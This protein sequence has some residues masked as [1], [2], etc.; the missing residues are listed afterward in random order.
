MGLLESGPLEAVSPRVI[1]TTSFPPC[2]SKVTRCLGSTGRP[3]SGSCAWFWVLIL[4]PITAQHVK[5][6]AGNP[7]AA[8]PKACGT[9]VQYLITMR[10]QGNG[11]VEQPGV[12]AGLPTVL[13]LKVLH[14]NT[15]AISR[16]TKTGT[17][18]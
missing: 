7:T 6:C 5:S 2:H 17:Q 18:S 3:G 11:G 14:E 8:A 12:G 15:I 16:Q 9:S 1:L 10:L 4:Q 13:P